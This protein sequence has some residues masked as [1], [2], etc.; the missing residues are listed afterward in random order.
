MSAAYDSLVNRGE[1]L[2][3]FYVA[4]E[5][6]EYLRK[7]VFAGW[8]RRET[9]EYDRRSTPRQRLRALRGDYF[10]DD[11]REYL[12]A[13]AATA[14]T[15]GRVQDVVDDPQWE[16]RLTVWHHALLEALG[17]R[18]EPTE[19]TV[20]RAGRDHTV[21]VAF[22]GDGIVAVDCGWAPTLDAALDP[23][24]PGS[25]LLAP[26]RASGAEHYDTGTA[27]A[28][29]LFQ[30]ELGGQGGPT[31]RFVLLLH[32]GVVILADRRTWYE[33]RYLAAILD[34]ALERNDRAQQGELATLAALFCHETLRPGDND[35]ATVLDDILRKSGT[36]AAGVDKD[37]RHGLKKS[38]EILAN[39]VLLRMAE[40]SNAITPAELEDPRTP[41]ARELTREC[42]RYL[43]RII[44]LL[45][46]EARPELGIVPADDTTYEAGYSMAHLRELVAGDRKL[47]DTDAA[48]GF[49][50]YQSL[51]VLFDAVNDGHP[52]QPGTKAAARRRVPA[53]TRSGV[54]KGLRFEGLRSEL[55]DPAA[56]RLIR[57]DVPDPRFDDGSGRRLDLRPRNDALHR[58]LRLLTMKEA[59]TGRG[60]PRAGRRG[61][62]I[63]YRNLG[64]N[65]LGA[66]YEGLMSYTG[67]I[68]GEP[69]NEVRKSGKGEQGTWL[70][71]ARLQD[72]YPES[73]LV[74]YDEADQL[75]GKRGP[76]VHET[77]SFAYR[78]SGRDR[79][80]TASYYTPEALTKVTVELA[81]K[82]RLDQQLDADGG[83]IRTRA[84][85]LLRW[86]VCEPALGSGAFLNEAINQLADEYLKRRQEERG[87]TIPT[88]QLVTEKQRVKAY[89]ALHNA[90]GVDL[91]PAGIELAEVSLW[92]NTMHRGMRAPWFGLHLRRGNSLIGARRAV[93]SAADVTSPAKAWLKAKGGLAPTPLPF[94][95]DGQRQALPAGAVHQFLLPNPGW[96]AITGGKEAKEA[97]PLAEEQLTRLGTWK[98]GILQ[99]PKATG[100]RSSEANRLRDAARRVE[101]LW[102][103]VIRRMEIS[104]EA[105]ARRIDVWGAAPDD[106]EFGFLRRPQHAVPKEQVLEDLFLA[107]DTPYW[108]LKKV[109]DAWCALWYWPLDKV[110][111]LTGATPE[112]GPGSEVSSASLGEVPTGPPTSA[113]ASQLDL[114]AAL[115]GSD[116]DEGAL[117][118][119]AQP[120]GY[121]P[122]AEVLIPEQPNA[123]AV[124]GV[125]D[126]P[127]VQVRE[128][129]PPAKSPKEKDSSK[130][131]RAT[132]AAPRTA[133]PLLSLNN[134]LDFLEAMLGS[135]DIPDDTL[136]KDLTTLDQLKVYEETLP[137]LMGM[138][139]G[140]PE[141]R[142]PW[143]HTVE[144]I[145]TREGFLHWEL[146]FAHVFTQSGGFDLQVGNPPWV[147]PQW[148]ENAVLAESDPWFETEEKP[149]AKDRAERREEL[150]SHA[151]A[152]QRFLTELTK[153]SA[154]VAY[155]SSPQVYPLIAGTQ[156]DLY[157]AFMWQTWIH[158]SLAGT[159]GMLHPDTHFTGDNEGKIREEA[160]SRLR[161]HGDFVN[162][163]RFFPPPIGHSSHFGVHIYGSP[164][165]IYFDNLSWLVSPDA[166]R[167]SKSHDG[168][169]EVPG[170]RYRNAEYD[171][172]PHRSRVVEITPETL[173]IWQRL[174]DDKAQPHQQARL[175]SPVS[176]GEA[177]AIAAL[178]AYPLRLGAFDAPIARGFDE[179]GAKEAG[180]IDYDRSSSSGGEY[181]P[182]DWGEVILKGVQ[183]A[184]ATPVFKRH[185]ANPNDPYGYNL[186]ELPPDFVPDTPYVPVEDNRAAFDAARDRDQWVD[187]AV[188]DRLREDPETVARLRY[189]VS[190]TT[191]LIGP[192]F[193]LAVEARLADEARRPY[194]HFY[195]LAWRAQI[196]PDTERALYGALIPPGASHVHGVHST[197]LPEPRHTVLLGGFWS[198]LPVDYFLRATG[199]GHVQVNSAK[200]MPAP[201]RHYPLAS[202]LLL[203]TLRLNCLTSA[204]AD[205][206]A[207]L[208]DPAWPQIENWALRWPDLADLNDVTPNWRWST[209]LRSEYARRA[210]LVEIDALVAVWIGM[211]ADALI[212]AYRGRFPV[213]QKYD[214]VTW[215]DAD[216]WKIAGNARTYGQRQT[217]ES[218][219]QFAAYREF[220]DPTEPPKDPRKVPKGYTG[221]FYQANREQEM[222][223]AHAV[224]QQRLDD[225]VTRGEWD[226]VTREVPKR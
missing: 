132:A 18:P 26:L 60:A 69:L 102:S 220:Q 125:P 226:P 205:L 8:S 25:R 167:S 156:P 171:E 106:E 109:M 153:V 223:A 62:F 211:S 170:V 140:D 161:V 177:D 210:A 158:S 80:T 204:Y 28:G 202:A 186:V 87:E 67:T 169:G 93:Y 200:S 3:A 88:R 56:I 63:S 215:F 121:D 119:A 27:L 192:D 146:E 37:L 142:F 116:P 197:A 74:K 76:V 187:H 81:L 164:R 9:D 149:T 157:R 183:I 100:G 24:G 166:L 154:Q 7:N 194:T 75:D 189:D 15:A 34:V 53:V 33:G 91:N 207:E 92:L 117:E 218:W 107:A 108:R 208:F 135:A 101:F 144:D 178:A 21:Q 162:A 79:E 50:L 78:L 22:H 151:E 6:G 138:G 71:P 77:G 225:A 120:I 147:R 96:A 152:S 30:G 64:I 195:R 130:G 134:W 73:A 124:P 196:A 41:F 168:S 176:T 115:L 190:S 112:Y 36:S 84:A 222:R 54:D 47:I 185:D 159:I 224:F 5:L 89:I 198:S 179:A 90:Y 104:E 163:G 165:E 199:L 40:P 105:I 16:K 31:P 172:R 86:R 58:V 12:S 103:L 203:R 148:K 123:A 127:A 214:S 219:A 46:A 113:V 94:Q 160:Y 188:L 216:G 122:P 110:D 145:A 131:R 206:W 217:K 42:L 129:G 180:L 85:E 72:K 174:L 14:G 182:A 111:L 184:T 221:P 155:L 209:P 44:F 4:E 39:E 10:S 137:A 118:E 70:I 99:R 213:L 82:H 11:V 175:L 193:D 59:A 35:T 57:D 29:W 1:Y 181:Q 17:F 45:F 19:L 65:Q 38:V 141:E 48:E 83:T 97:R 55:F 51:R 95:A 43:Y 136:F 32:G 114:L 2:S 52:A 173:R 139:L 126:R 20:H 128:V 68:A 212:A 61:G 13:A 150:L 49:Y 98:K 66:V 23:D 133:V 191:D 143:L 201:N